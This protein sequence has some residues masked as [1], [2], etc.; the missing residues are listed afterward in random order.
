[1]TDVPAIMHTG[2]IPSMDRTFQSGQQAI[3]GIRAP[4]GPLP[5]VIAIPLL[6]ASPLP[7]RHFPLLVSPRE[8]NRREQ[9]QVLDRTGW[10]VPAG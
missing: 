6:A 5:G 10:A 4:P 7:P 1:M 9:Q 8:F 2:G 3:S